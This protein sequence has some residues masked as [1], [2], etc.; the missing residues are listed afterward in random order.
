MVKRV[1]KRAVYWRGERSR[2]GRF[3]VVM[4]GGLSDVAGC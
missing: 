4:L 1:R 3:G 2:D